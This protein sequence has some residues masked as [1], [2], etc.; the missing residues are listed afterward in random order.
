MLRA[1]VASTFRLEGHE[2]ELAA[3]GHAIETIPG[4]SHSADGTA[5]SKTD[6]APPSERQARIAVHWPQRLVRQG[7]ELRVSRSN[8]TVMASATPRSGRVSDRAASGPACGTA[9]RLGE[10]AQ[11]TVAG[12]RQARW[13]S[14]Y[15]SVAPPARVCSRPRQVARRRR[16]RA[17]PSRGA[18]SS[19]RCACGQRPGPSPTAPRAVRF[20]P[21]IFAFEARPASPVRAR[22]CAARSAGNHGQC[23]SLRADVPP[24]KARAS[25]RRHVA[26]QGLN[27]AAIRPCGGAAAAGARVSRP[28]RRR[29][30]SCAG[31]L[32]TGLLDEA[33]A[34]RAHHQS[35]ALRARRRGACPVPQRPGSSSTEDGRLDV[36]WL[37]GVAFSKVVTLPQTSRSSPSRPSSPVARS[38]GRAASRL[39]GRRRV[40]ARLYLRRPAP[41]GMRARLRGRGKET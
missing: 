2:H 14:R 35:T 30:R 28:I 26:D 9:R 4:T 6:E 23:L 1:E 33:D 38:A 34:V 21:R 41:N 32:G 22:C 31:M 29:L 24:R 37:H 12:A 5:D 39:A 16:M 8:E 25:E 27:A 13:I 11:L 19:A 3:T 17:T 40:Q 18:P 36:Q 7:D 20:K 15:S 10:P